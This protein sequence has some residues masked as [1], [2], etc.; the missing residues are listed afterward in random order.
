MSDQRISKRA[1][2]RAGDVVRVRPAADILASLDEK[3]CTEGLPFMPEMLSACGRVVRVVASAHKTCDTVNSGGARQTK[4]IVHLTDLRCDGSAHGGCQ[5]E[6]LLFWHVDWLE[7]ARAGDADAK[8]AG[9]LPDVTPLESHTSDRDAEGELVYS[10]QA[11]RL[12][13]FSQPVNPLDPR[14]FVKDWTSGNVPLGTLVDGL[15]FRLVSNT[16][17]FAGY[18]L[19]IG[20]YNRIAAWRGDIPYPLV[21]GKAKEGTPL[22]RLHLEPGERVRVKSLR[23]IEETLDERQRNRGLR[24]DWEMA[25][26]SG[27]EMRVRSLVTRIINEKSGRM[28]EFSNPCV[29]L[30]GGT[31]PSRFSDRGRVGCPRAINAYFRENWLERIDE[32]SA[33]SDAPG[34]ASPDPSV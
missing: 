32:E 29:V 14:P 17:R 23:A 34:S 25:P 5:A 7:P 6:C 20:L 27:R 22:E 31:C 30:E 12:M 16:I 15:L 18:R 13:D 8:G 28:M 10:C 24:Y 2:L 33:T 26:H 4:H 9:E 19:L 3:G 1:N 21:R 11:T